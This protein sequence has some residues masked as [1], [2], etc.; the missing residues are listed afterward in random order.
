[1]SFS[2]QF[3]TNDYNEY[4]CSEYD[5]FFL[6]TMDP[7]PIDRPDGNL[8]VDAKGDPISVNSSFLRAC[9]AGTYNGLTYSCPLGSAPLQGTGYEGHAAT[10]WLETTVGVTP[11]SV[12][13]LRFMIWDS[14]DGTY[15][16][17]ALVDGITFSASPAKET[18][19][20]AK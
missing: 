2:H 18:V 6:A 12:V 16:S 1:M 17:T 20:I 11:S 10:G 8:A 13:T 5:D 15:D 9:A 19:T 4:V 14:G 3:F 7:H